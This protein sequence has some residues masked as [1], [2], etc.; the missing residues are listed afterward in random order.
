MIFFVKIKK[1]AVAAARSH[2][3]GLMEVGEELGR[4]GHQVT[5]VSPQRYKTVPPNVTDIVI[6]SEFEA[7]SNRMTTEL[8]ANDKPSVPPFLEVRKTK[9]IF[10]QKYLYKDGRTVQD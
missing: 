6:D 3:I 10:T 7:L 5:V 8:V 1:S 2:K 9:L 4:R